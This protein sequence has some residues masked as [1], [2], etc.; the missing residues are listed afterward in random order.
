MNKEDIEQAVADLVEAVRIDA[1]IVAA[2]HAV[3]VI[4]EISCRVDEGSESVAY[5]LR[6]LKKSKRD[7]PA[8]RERLLLLLAGGN[9]SSEQG[10]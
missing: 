1:A 4:D 2:E 5:H 6:M 10:V 9:I 7:V 3:S 8:L